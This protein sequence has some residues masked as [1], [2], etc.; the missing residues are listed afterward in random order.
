[1]ASNGPPDTLSDRHRLLATYI[2]LGYS[3]EDAG[4]ELKMS[5]QRVSIIRQSPLFVHEVDSERK[6]IRERITTDAVTMLGTEA[7]PSVR[8]LVEL[9]DQNDN[10]AVA[11]GSADSILDRVIPRQVKHEEERTVRIVFDAETMTELRETLI[12]D[13]VLA[14]VEAAA[15]AELPRALRTSLVA[16]LDDV[17]AEAR[18]AELS[19][20]E[21]A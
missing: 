20:A 16:T 19:L 1:M 10:L 9:R 6:R 11:K 15:L 7:V 14:D 12:E 21:S 13:G 8:R 4:R 17:I 5:A 2:A 18:A 3:N